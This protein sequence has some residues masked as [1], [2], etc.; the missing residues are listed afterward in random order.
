MKKLKLR[1][2]GDLLWTY[3]KPQAWKVSLLAFL[4]LS[5]I[6]LQLLNPQIVRSFID[7]VTSSGPTSQLLLTALLF[8]VVGVSQQLVSAFTTYFSTDVGWTATNIMRN[9]LA[10]HVL[11]LDMSFHN[12]TV[13][14]QLIERI[15]GDVALLSTFFAEFVI[16]VLG[17]LILLVGVLVLLL[18]EDWRI[19]LT[20][21]VFT[22]LTLLVLNGIRNI[23]VPA[24]QA[25]RQADAEVF[26]FLEERLAG[27]EDIRANG[28]G[29]YSMRRFF[30]VSRQLFEKAK[31]ASILRAT[32]WAST[33][34]MFTLGVTLTLTIGAW[35]Y[36]EHQISLGTV[37]LF[38]QYSMLLRGPI[39]Q[40]SRQLQEL[41]KAVA[42]IQRIQE[43]RE[44]KPT[45]TDKAV[46]T[47]KA[48]TESTSSV[49]QGALGVAFEKVW[50]G[51]SSDTIVLKDV[52]FTLQ[53]G[54]VLGVLGR[55]GSGKSTLT[56]LLFRLYEPTQGCISLGGIATQHISLE[57]L[58]QH[59]GLV[60]QE[61]QLFHATVRDNMTF[62]DDSVEEARI[63]EVLEDL[64]LQSW[65]NTLPQGLD[66]W[67][68]GASGGLSAGEAQLLA[69]AR[70]FL[71]NP[72]LVILDEPSS[73]LDPATESLIERAV[74]KLL[75]ARSGIIIAHRLA[76]VQRADYIL[77]MEEGS[78]AE[79]GPRLALAADPT[80][81]FYQ[82]LQAGLE[83][84]ADNDLASATANTFEW[85]NLETANLEEELVS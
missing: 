52:S 33:M 29:A 31:P 78:I 71:R 15:D 27:I 42:G 35:L 59:I 12:N 23:A 34:F 41:Q 11:G 21:M 19:S 7:T 25:E 72:G 38:F 51:Y 4:L 75:Q 68:E 56:R 82:M 10:H 39:G 79:Y 58:R 83:N 64:G 53:P 18:G 61:V 1:Q 47:S 32:I 44:L 26:G 37:Y 49:P 81:R 16:K 80:S 22:L 20:L 45:I 76:T 40:I 14:G 57:A 73:R 67:L 43:L 8:T 65:Y 55:T 60:M 54:H 6:G 62:F 3:L 77:I 85:E 50:F 70:V 2:Y 17:S 28:G 36:F 13:P 66:S 24:M 84:L 63:L 5:S 30:E 48:K 46:A 9:D 74:D 69:F